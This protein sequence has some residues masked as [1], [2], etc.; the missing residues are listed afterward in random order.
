[1]E[2]FSSVIVSACAVSITLPLQARHVMPGG[3][4]GGHSPRIWVGVCSCGSEIPTLNG[5]FKGKLVVKSRPLFRDT[6]HYLVLFPY[7]LH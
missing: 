4:G 7:T 1:M 5:N 3:G 6:H 2:P